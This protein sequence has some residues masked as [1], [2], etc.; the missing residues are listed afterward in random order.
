MHN[1]LTIEHEDFLN[2]TRISAFARLLQI[3]TDTFFIPK[4]R[5]ALS[6]IEGAEFNATFPKMGNNSARIKI[7]DKRI[8]PSPGKTD[9]PTGTLIFNMKY[10][11]LQDSVGEIVRTRSNLMGLA[12]LF[13]KFI[14]PGKIKMK[15]AFFKILT[16]LKIILLGNHPMYKKEKK[17]T[18]I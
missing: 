12:K 13:F 8:H 15:G 1:G 17:L 18:N 3:L 2:Q 4:N 9:N 11:D 10:K 5:E 7:I 6:K 16:V 14:L